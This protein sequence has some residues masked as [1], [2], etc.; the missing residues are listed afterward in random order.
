M[1]YSVNIEVAHRVLRANGSRHTQQVRKLVLIECG[2]AIRRCIADSPM[3]EKQSQ[4]R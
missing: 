3:A 2:E 1:S 4:T